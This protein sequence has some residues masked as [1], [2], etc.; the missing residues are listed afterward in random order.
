MLFS[1]LSSRFISLEEL[2]FALVLAAAEHKVIISDLI[3]RSPP[4]AAMLK[5]SAAPDLLLEF[6][7]RKH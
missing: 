4:T 2:I 1:N 3:A 7:Q 5:P 6:L